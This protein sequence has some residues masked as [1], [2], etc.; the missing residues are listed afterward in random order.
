MN[1]MTYAFGGFNG[2]K[3]VTAGIFLLVALSVPALAQTS[4]YSSMT[5]AGDFTAW[6][7]SR[8]NMILVSNNTWETTIA[9]TASRTNFFKFTANGSWSVNWGKSGIQ[10]N[11]TPPISQTADLFGGDIRI[12]N[13]NEGV[14]R[15]R[16]NTS[17]KQFWIDRLGQ[18]SETNNLLRNG[19]FETAG[20]SDYDAYYWEF[21]RPDTHGDNWGNSFREDYRYFDGNWMG[22]V[23]ADPVNFGGWYQEVPFTPDF[24]YSFSGFFYIDPAW[25]AAV[26]EVKVEYFNNAYNFL[27]NTVLALTNL[28]AAW[29]QRTF[30]SI[31]PT[32]TTWARTVINVSGA[33]TKGTL[34]FDALKVEARTKATQNFNSW[35]SSDFIGAH[36]RAGWLVNSGFVSSVNARST[37]SANLV[38]PTASPAGGY[39]QSGRNTNGIGTVSFWYR[40]GWSDEDNSPNAPVTIVIQ[41]SPDGSNF[42]T[43]HTLT[44]VLNDFYRSFTRQF[45][46]T[47]QYYVRILHSGGSTNTVLVD[48]ISIDKPSPQILYQDFETWTPAT[49]ICLTSGGWTVCTGSITAVNAFDGLSALLSPPSLTFSNTI[50][51]PIFSNGIGTVSFQYA[52]GTNGIG[53][54]SMLIQSSTNGSTWTTLDTV[55]QILDSSY[56]LYEKT[57]FVTKPSYL[58]IA[59]RFVTN[60]SLNGIVYL[61]EGFSGGTTAPVGWVFSGVG[62]YTTEASS[63]KAVPSLKFDD[64]GDEIITPIISGKPT[65]LSFWAKGQTSSGGSVL[66]IEGSINAGTNWLVM[67]AFTNLSGTEATYNVTVVNTNMNRFRVSYFKVT[68]NVAFDDFKLIGSLGNNVPPPQGLFVDNINVSEPIEFREQ[69]FDGW[70]T[71]NDYG[72]YTYQGWIAG[73]RVLI[74]SVNAF[75]GQAARLDNPTNAQPYIQSPLLSEGIGTIS[76]KYRH[77]DGTPT[78][79]VL[80]QISANGVNWST[81]DTLNVSSTSYQTYSRY[82][83]STTNFALRILLSGGADR[84]LLDEIVVSKPAPPAKLVINASITP[85]APFTNDSVHILANYAP[86]FGAVNIG[87]TSYYRVG[88][89]GV[90]TIIPMVITNN[91]QFGT[92]TPIPPKPTNTIVQYFIKASFSGPGSETN[93]PIFYPPGGSNSPASYGIARIRPGSVWINEVKYNDAFVDAGIVSFVELAGKG[94]VNLNGWRMQFVNFISTNVVVEGSYTMGITHAIED[95]ESGYGFWVIGTNV[96]IADMLLTNSLFET[97]LGIRLL[98]ELGFV[99]D[100]VSFGG[101]IPGY[102]GVGVSD[103]DAFPGETGISLIGTGQSN[104][105]FIWTNEVPVTPRGIN[106]GQT[107]GEPNPPVFIEPPDIYDLYIVDGTIYLK[108]Y[109]NTN[110]FTVAPFSTTDLYPNPASWQAVT[111]FNSTLSGGTNTIWFNSPTNTVNAIFYRVRYL[112]P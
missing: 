54:A 75:A 72:T 99:E 90:F 18:V 2:V 15:F 28:S 32:G 79:T 88:T 64:T 30:T 11:T 73:N 108:S 23:G 85:S 21:N 84:L 25:T 4:L 58:R 45:N 81:L 3:R 92:V 83:N 60:V 76:F 48:D 80:V 56:Q 70:P 27:G 78:L 94:G 63:G 10:S 22:A 17:T 33:G 111:P 98:N 34:E 100:A 66:T 104:D 6:D 109:G 69:D 62:T 35:S 38:N 86:S 67:T 61:D 14:H 95:E 91:I 49:N 71:Q 44:N 57:F 97:P 46:F 36:S 74:N 89:S 96:M 102:Y 110:S 42:S 8:N 40:H 31:A 37:L 82:L 55:D 9:L 47:N 13:I 68:G 20:S 77:W 59:S 7:P 19:S 12:N 1:I 50:T 93:S 29:Q 103:L 26:Q 43:V 87:M 53:P 101:T 5:L 107:F 24:E 105:D 52:R 16:F 51:S 106:D 112:P 65:N 39:I 41:A